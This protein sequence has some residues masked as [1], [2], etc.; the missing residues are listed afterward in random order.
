MAEAFDPD[1]LDYAHRMFELAR[2]GAADELS[3]Q[4]DAG[5]P[6]NL[7]NGKGDTLLMLAA[8]RP[9]PATVQALL[10]RG[11]DA[12]RINDR[13]QTALGA[14]AFRQSREAVEALLAAG[15]DPGLGQPSAIEVA[16][17]FDLPEMVELLERAGPS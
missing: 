4:V 16:R 11:A 17:F 8:Y 1:V 9:H 7:T 3:A 6:V 15:A 2:Q 5:L 13:G 14:A 10:D 12:A